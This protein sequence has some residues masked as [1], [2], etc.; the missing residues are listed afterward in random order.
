MEEELETETAV[1]LRKS[2]RERLGGESGSCKRENIH[3]FMRKK[4]A[5]KALKIRMPF[6]LLCTRRLFFRFADCLGAKRDSADPEGEGEGEGEE[7][8]T[9]TETERRLGWETKAR[10]EVRGEEWDREK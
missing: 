2:K 10:G 6:L 3:Q 8:E 9:E 1:I 5:S 7:E 4:K